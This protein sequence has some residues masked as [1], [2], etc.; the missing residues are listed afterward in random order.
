[1]IVDN[2]DSWYVFSF[3]K[4]HYYQADDDPAPYLTY[5]NK[6]LTNREYLEH[7]GKWVFYGEGKELDEMANNLD[8]YVEEGT[9]PCIKYE[10]KS[11]PWS[12]REKCVMCIF[13]DDREKGVEQLLSDMGVKEKRWMYDREV[14][15]KWMPGGEKMEQWIEYR[16]LNEEQ[17]ERLREDARRRFEKILKRP[18]DICLPW[19]Q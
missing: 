9:I 15:E 18:D 13:C 16:G 12:D 8:P 17:A 5:R 11:P 2:P 3:S 6:R 14:I 1:M 19:G 10:R 4:R 7:W